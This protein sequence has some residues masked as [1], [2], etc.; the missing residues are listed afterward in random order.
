MEPIPDHC[1]QSPFGR[2]SPASI[3]NDDRFN[4]YRAHI[5]PWYQEIYDK[6]MYVTCGYTCPQCGS[7]LSSTKSGKILG[8]LASIKHLKAAG[9]ADEVDG[10]RKVK[11]L[12]APT[13]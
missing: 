7:Y 6:Y 11:S 5:V 9:V 12:D 2:F 4:K 1:I 13:P 8:H 10:R 3:K